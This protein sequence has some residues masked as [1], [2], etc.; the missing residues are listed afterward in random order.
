MFFKGDEAK[1][2]Y[3]FHESQP[4]RQKRNPYKQDIMDLE[5]KSVEEWEDTDTEKEMKKIRPHR[6]NKPLYTTK[7]NTFR[8]ETNLLRKQRFLDNYFKQTE[9]EKQRYREEQGRYI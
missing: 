5:K 4:T 2:T 3:L 9:K 7:K 8:T 6:H 1:K